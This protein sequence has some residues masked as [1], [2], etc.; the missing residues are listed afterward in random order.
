[1]LI[2]NAKTKIRRQKKIGGKKYF[3]P[4]DQIILEDVR[5]HRQKKW[6]AT[7]HFISSLEKNLQFLHAGYQLDENS[8]SLVILYIL[9]QKSS[10]YCQRARNLW[11]FNKRKTSKL[12]VPKWMNLYFAESFWN[13]SETTVFHQL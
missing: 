9:T 7:S 12:L 5:Y 4:T 11:S 3:L 10:A 8:L 13:L 2:F 6:N 1:M